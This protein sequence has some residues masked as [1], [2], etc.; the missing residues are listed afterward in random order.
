MPVFASRVS[1]ALDVTNHFCVSFAGCVEAERSFDLVVLQ[2]AVDGFGTT[3]NLHA[4]LLSGIVFSEDA[5][6]GIGVVA[7]DDYDSVETE[8][9]DYFH[10]LLKLSHFFELCATRTNHVETTRVAVFIDEGVGHLDV[11]VVH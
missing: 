7:T 10:T 1:I 11:V 4:I 2:V 3:D 6:V 8:L 9:A 5:S